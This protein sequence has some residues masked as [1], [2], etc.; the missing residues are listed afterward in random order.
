MTD[1]LG[2]MKMKNSHPI[3]GNEKETVKRKRRQTTDREK[4]FATDTPEPRPLS[5]IY[6]ELFKLN[7]TEKQT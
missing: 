6:R 4:M 3:K 5:E 7:N 1:T 2:S